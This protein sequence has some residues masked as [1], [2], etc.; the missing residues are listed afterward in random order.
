MSAPPPDAE[1]RPSP[2]TRIPASS[3]GA[4]RFVTA[5]L[6]ASIGVFAVLAGTS[7]LIMI[8]GEPLDPAASTVPFLLGWMAGAGL[9]AGCVGILAGIA[10]MVW[11]HRAHDNLSRMQT[12]RFM[13]S[14]VWWWLVPVASLFMP[15]KAIG[16]LA[17]AE[18]DRPRLRRWWWGLYLA[19]GVVSAAG[20]VLAS[21]FPNVV[22]T[23]SLAAGSYLLGIAA[24]VAAIRVVRLIDHG[25]EGRRAKLG[26]PRGWSPLPGR[27]QTVWGLLAAAAAS[28]GG[29]A[30]GLALPLFTQTIE[31]G[32]TAERIDFAVG[33]CFDDEENFLQADC[34][35]PHD[36][37]VYALLIHP[38]QTI[39]P[40][41]RLI[42]DWAE[43]LCYSRFRAYT[44]VAYE[45]S[46]IDFG[47]LYPTSAA[48]AAG[49]REVV[50]YLFDPS[51][52]RLTSPI[53][54]ATG[55]A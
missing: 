5:T 11:Q 2:K 33:V 52:D 14:S 27:V 20:A 17:G 6:G 51:G 40:G 46:T 36:S 29:L 53:G 19:F 49:D 9:A 41:Q 4:G 15:F 35:E 7:L 24:A 39:Y 30:L 55:R 50:C 45:N 16:E 8:R 13:P 47:Y 1:A 48:W 31:T 26:W 54:T 10:W 32:A 42:E 22:W 3:T 44:G 37:E 23:E 38:D 18:E 21:A 12:T 43:P 34:T 25:I 28:M